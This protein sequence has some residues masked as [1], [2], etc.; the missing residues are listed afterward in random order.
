MEAMKTEGPGQRE[1]LG[2]GKEAG[3]HLSPPEDP[4]GWKG[5]RCVAHHCK[6]RQIWPRNQPAT[7]RELTVSEN[8]FWWRWPGA[9][10][11]CAVVWALHQPRFRLGGRR[12]EEEK[13][14]PLRCAGCPGFVP[15]VMEAKWRTS[16]LVAQTQC[17]PGD[18]RQEFSWARLGRPGLP[19]GGGNSYR[20]RPGLT[21]AGVWAK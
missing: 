13:G 19:G 3:G 6:Q 21:V 12:R 7:W 9:R 20:K 2:A 16:H 5:Y 15:P 8:G 18:D 10:G 1:R 17:S 11:V 4:K 14:R